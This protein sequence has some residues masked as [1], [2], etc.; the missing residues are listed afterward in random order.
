[1]GI[2][3]LIYA[4]ALA[5]SA[6]F[7]V[8]YPFWFA[9]YLFLLILL[10]LPFDFLISLPG[11]L[12][13]HI[14][15]SS[16]K[17]L[18]SGDDGVVVLVAHQRSKFPARCVKLWLKVSGDDFTTWRRFVFGA[19]EGCRYEVSIDTSRT[20]V[21][22]FES[23]RLWTVSLI[24]LFCL[25]NNDI[26]RSSVLVLPPPAKPPH[27]VALPRGI[28]LKPK[29]GGGF[30]EDYDLRPYRLGDPIRSV[31][32]K[33]S[34]KFDSL[35]IREPLVPPSHSRLL[36]IT[37]WN[38]AKER[39]LI[40][41]RVRWVSDYLLKWDLAHYVRFGEKGPI[42]EVTCDTDLLGYLYLVLNNATQEL[43]TPSTIPIRF[44]WV[45]R[46]DGK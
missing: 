7:F 23:K 38:D 15:I 6:I 42:T 46:V 44:A 26:V 27:T 18:E 11:M 43:R 5:G 20:G 17:I 37:E 25:P 36:F 34:A 8:L 33:V 14:T 9:W 16:P 3:R 28:I 13:R 1:M 22:V 29:L 45:F 10:L 35:I 2:S 31:H 19:G 4:C 39:D 21:T 41:S 40:L 32:W 12:T 24:G 30:S